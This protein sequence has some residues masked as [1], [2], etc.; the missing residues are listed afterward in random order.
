MIKEL[1]EKLS[2]KLVLLL[3]FITNVIYMIML[4]YSLPKVGGYA[5]DL[6]LFDMSPSG[7]SYSIAINLLNELGPKGRDLYLSLQLPL[8][9]IYPMLFSITYS[10]LILWLVKRFN[11]NWSGFLWVAILPIAAGLFDYAENVG[12]ILMLMHYPEVSEGLVQLSSF[13]TVIKSILTTF[14]F[15]AL[16][17]VLLFILFRR[18]Q[19]NKRDTM[20]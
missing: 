11:L 20:G 8:D 6:V 18:H 13:F 4:F 9:F 3:F 15:V 12:I 1:R 17:M 19:Q 7:Y 5:S 2:G 14:Y 10:L 16:L